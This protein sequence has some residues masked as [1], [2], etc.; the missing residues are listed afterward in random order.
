M[1]MGRTDCSEERQTGDFKIGWIYKNKQVK[2]KHVA[3]HSTEL[4]RV[5]AAWEYQKSIKL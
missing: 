3:M 2:L 4:T 1:V 5:E